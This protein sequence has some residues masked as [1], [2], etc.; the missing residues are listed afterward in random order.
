LESNKMR[1]SLR[2]KILCYTFII[3]VGVLVYAFPKLKVAG[4]DVS[5]TIAMFLYLAIVMI[6]LFSIAENLKEMGLKQAGLFK[7]VV[8]KII[9]KATG[10]TVTEEQL[11][12][13]ATVVNK[14]NGKS[15][16]EDEMK[17]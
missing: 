11:S 7:L 5:A 3:L 4:I 2:T 15:T 1:E 14:D 9:F 10:I 17:G 16:K 8:E 6:E 13:A 12:G